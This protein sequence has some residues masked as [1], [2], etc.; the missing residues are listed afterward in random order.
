M[1]PVYAELKSALSRWLIRPRGPESGSIL[2]AQRRIYI[3]PTRQGLT[4][5]IVLLLMLLGSIN[6]ALSLGFV[7]TFMLAAMGVNA[8]LYT[9]R[10]LARLRITPGR[11][12]A[13]FAGETAH[14]SLC[15]ENST[16]ADRFSIGLTRDRKTVSFADVPSRAHVV[17]AAGVRAEKRGVLRPGR[18]TLCTQYPLGLFYAWS[19]I[20]LEMTCIVYPRPAFP[21][22]PLPA[23]EPSP[24]QGSRH[25]QGQE[26]FAGLR[27]YHTGDS[28]RHIA[29]KAVARGQG[30]LTKQ[31]SGRAD[32]ELWL[33]WRQLPAHYH[34]EE[35]L[36]MLARWVID[37]DALG[38]T[39]GLRLP[40]T[41]VTLGTGSAHRS[42][43][44][45]A[46]ALYE[47]ENAGDRAKSAQPA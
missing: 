32:S 16:A 15:I 20:H 22:L 24:G 38:M 34:L 23:P 4:F 7:L 14:F 30:L 5:G 45:E 43:C 11:S 31:F 29:W 13:V 35:R 21:A 2:L 6:Y 44:L 33:D 28:P 12:Q 42:R 47:V 37:A 46:L 17:L 26:D 40:G 25:G 27:Q 19:H 41:T 36:S 1:M 39:Y 9:F 18:L 3:L 8:M 10:N